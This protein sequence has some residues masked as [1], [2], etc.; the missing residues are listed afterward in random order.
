[1]GSGFSL[2]DAREAIFVVCLISKE[3]YW[4]RL[5]CKIRRGLD[6]KWSASCILKSAP[7]AAEG[8]I[9]TEALD[10]VPMPQCCPALAGAGRGSGSV[11]EH[12]LAKE[13]VEGSNPFFRS[14]FFCIPSP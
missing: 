6:E 7:A 5:P 12:L 9:E 11:V 10:F 3:N 14:N 4:M 8:S 2:N 13:G 1:M